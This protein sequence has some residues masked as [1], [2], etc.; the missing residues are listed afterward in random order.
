MS[1]P[2]GV[3]TMTM[4]LDKPPSVN[5]EGIPPE[6]KA[7]RQW[8]LWKHET[9]SAKETKVPYQPNGSHAKTNEPRTW[10]TFAAV[11]A[12]YQHGGLDGIGV[13]F[14]NDVVGADLDSC[15]D[16]DG[17]LKP[18]AADIV[19]DLA[20]PTYTEVSPSRL[21][22]H[23]L[24]FGALPELDR[25]RFDIGP[26]E[27]VEFYGFPSNRFFTVTG[28]QWGIV[29]TV[30]RVEPVDFAP[31]LYYI[32][33]TFPPKERT[34]PPAPPSPH[35]EVCRED[36]D[37]IRMA[38]RAR[39]SGKVVALLRGDTAGYPSASEADAALCAILAHYTRDAGQIDR[40]FRRSGLYRDKWDQRHHADG[41]T[42]GQATID[43]A[44]ALNGGAR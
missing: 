7:L 32:R 41:R 25:H 26:H 29:S 13:C 6:L 24:Y 14:G 28:R 2:L 37:I 36:D 40:I 20:I 4:T 44:L 38:G 27:G 35:V 10:A 16:D 9:R 30:T 23:M 1:K 19:N 15:F 3:M 18:W 42:Y 17:T 31:V 21:G 5:V 39:N 12:A 11:L 43:R 33:E 8:V 34:Q 22:L